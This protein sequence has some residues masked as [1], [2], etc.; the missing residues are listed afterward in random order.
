MKKKVKKIATIIDTP[1]VWKN[2]KELKGESF[3]LMVMPKFK[4][5]D[6]VIENNLGGDI[7]VLESDSKGNVISWTE[8]SKEFI[9]DEGYQIL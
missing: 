5:C 6:Y 4:K 1:V 8:L 9:E 3:L 2:L 7:T